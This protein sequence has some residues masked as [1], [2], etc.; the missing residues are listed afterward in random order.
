MCVS[1]PPFFIACPRAGPRPE[2][3][4]SSHNPNPQFWFVDADKIRDRKESTTLPRMQELRDTDWLEQ[5][6]L[7]FNG[8]CGRT[9][10]A[11]YLAISHRWEDKSEPDKGG[12]QYVAVRDFLL[13]EQGRHIKWVWY[14]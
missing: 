4:P 3:S 2:P 9:F 8:A 6:P 1:F 10:V 14:E 13:S 7:N 11:D 5:H 12:K